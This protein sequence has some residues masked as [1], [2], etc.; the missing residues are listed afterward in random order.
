VQGLGAALLMPQTLTIITQVFPPARRGV[1]GLGVV[2]LALAAQPQ[3]AGAG[4][5]RARSPRHREGRAGAER[6]LSR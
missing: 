3:G 4:A 1:L 5:S 6:R 2:L